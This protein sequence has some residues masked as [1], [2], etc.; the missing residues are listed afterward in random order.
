[1]QMYVIPGGGL[2]PTPLGPQ[3]FTDYTAEF[4]LTRGPYALLGYS[5]ANCLGGNHTRP[6]AKEW[7]EDF[8]APLNHGAACAETG[9][10]TGVFERQ[11]SLATVKWDCAVGH[12]T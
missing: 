11:W 8:G 4:L 12:G 6:R 5:W 3:G 1:M 9:A 10:G 7:D 2:T